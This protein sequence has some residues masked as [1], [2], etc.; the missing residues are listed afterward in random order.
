MRIAEGSF[1]HRNFDNIRE[2]A[3]CEFHKLGRIKLKYRA[4]GDALI[5]YVSAL[6][7]F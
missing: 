3:S 6:Y 4:G 7:L 2:A 5:E 1:Q